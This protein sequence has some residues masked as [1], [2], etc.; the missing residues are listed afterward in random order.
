M[1][2]NAIRGVLL[3]LPVALAACG[4]ANIVNDVRTLT[5]ASRSSEQQ[6]LASVERQYANARIGGAAA[7]AMAGGLLA[8]A[9]GGNSRDIAIAAAAGSVAGYAGAAALTNQNANFALSR[10]TLQ[11]DIDSAQK[12]NAQMT[13][14]VA[15]ANSV[16]SYQRSEIARLNSELKTGAVTTDQYKAKV[17]LMQQD[18]ST[19]RSLRTEAEKRMSGL[20]KSVP[21]YRAKG[22]PTGDLQAQ[23]NAQ[24]ARV[25]ELRAAENAMVNNLANV[26]SSVS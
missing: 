6:N 8:A 20:E 24:K 11:R 4:D 22:L 13:R 21:A 12:E 19:V 5:S 16:V 26:P 25:A 7:G 15:A 17:A 9:M 14:A 3:A 10:D 1:K 18:V 2:H 23:L